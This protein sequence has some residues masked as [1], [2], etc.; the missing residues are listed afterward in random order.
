MTTCPDFSPLRQRLWDH[1]FEHPEWGMDAVRRLVA[2]QGWTLNDAREAVEEYRKFCFLAVVCP[3][4]V[5]PSHSVD[6]VWHTHLLYTH[7]YWEVF[8]PRVLGRALHHGPGNGPEEDTH[9]RQQYALTLAAYHE[10]FGPPPVKWWPHDLV[11]PSPH[12]R[13]AW[14]PLHQVWI[15]RKPLWIQRL[16]RF[17]RRTP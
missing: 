1:R 6:V 14:A 12:Q 3:H 7:D 17:W 9:F 15:V 16:L 8:C 4:S 10:H 13:W 5:T 2:E 11:P